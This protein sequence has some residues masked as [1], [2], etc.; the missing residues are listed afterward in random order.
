MDRQQEMERFIKAFL[1][2][3]NREQ[4]ATLCG[5]LKGEFI[6][7]DWAEKRLEVSY[8]AQAWQQNP[9]GRMH[10]GIQAAIADFT[11]ACL[12]DYLSRS[13]ALTVS[14]QISYLRP[15]PVSGNVIAKARATKSGRTL[16]HCLVELFQ[17]DKP[18]QAI[19]AANFVYMTGSMP[20]ELD[21]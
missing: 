4:A 20:L 12:C 18:E 17:E 13:Y 5:L 2:K 6:A 1:E 15:G 8:P 11:A 10:G 3:M 19:A 9:M 21:V 16:Q 14:M 7:C